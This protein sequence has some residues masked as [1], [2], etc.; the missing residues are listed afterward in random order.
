MN[1]I[2]KNVILP[3]II[4]M[5][6]IGVLGAGW[7]WGVTHTQA[8]T[9]MARGEG[10]GEFRPFGGDDETQVRPRPAGFSAKFEGREQRGEAS[11]GRGLGGVMGTLVK[12]SVIV[13][14]VL[15]IQRGLAGLNDW[16][17]RRKMPPAA[18]PNSA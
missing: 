10:S 1:R 15:L 2:V 8:F 11:L 5:V 14:L 6:V 17:A 12:L 16:F 13:V 4:L 3:L 18:P 9:G 7:W